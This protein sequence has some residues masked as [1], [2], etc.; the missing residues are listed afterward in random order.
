MATFYVCG[1]CKWDGNEEHL[2]VILVYLKR[3]VGYT[4]KD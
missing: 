4:R 3:D 1:V 2:E